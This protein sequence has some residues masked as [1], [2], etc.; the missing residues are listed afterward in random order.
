MRC[1][2]FILCL[3][4][5]HLM[6]QKGIRFVDT[7]TISGYYYMFAWVEP[8]RVKNWTGPMAGDDFF[9]S[10]ST[11]AGRSLDEYMDTVYDWGLDKEK[12][13]SQPP[14]ETFLPFE[15]ADS[16]T[17][18]WRPKMITIKSFI[19]G[20]KAPRFGKHKRRAWVTRVTVQWV[21]LDMDAAT[22]LDGFDR[23]VSIDAYAVTQKGRMNVYLPVKLLSIERHVKWWRKSA[24]RSGKR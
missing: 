8:Y 22:A 21:K 23:P 4:P 18:A 6:A 11:L 16:A 2:I 14:D 10:D 15:G 9:V 3:L 19:L 17:M 24:G 12:F 7:V 5:F 13:L 20:T 1:I